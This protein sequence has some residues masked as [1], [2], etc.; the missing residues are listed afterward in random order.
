MKRQGSCSKA[1]GMDYDDGAESYPMFYLNLIKFL[2][3]TGEERERGTVALNS[4]H[5]L[6]SV[7]ALIQRRAKN[8]DPGRQIEQTTDDEGGL[9]AEID[10]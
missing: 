4:R 1:I 6:F 9:Q 3:R 5:E 7:A 2:R 10:G 8:E